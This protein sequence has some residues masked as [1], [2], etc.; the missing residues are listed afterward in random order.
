[1]QGALTGRRE[2]LLQGLDLGRSLGAEIGPLGRPLVTRSDGRVVYIDHADAEHLRR[3]Y[4]DDPH[5]DTDRIEVDAVWGQDTLAQAV[6][7]HAGPVPLDYVVASHVIEH[8]PDLVTWLQEIAECLREHGHLRL[9]IPDRRYTFDILRRDS[10]L[11]AVLAA[12]ASRARVPSTHAVL[13]F[14]LHE[15]PVDTARAW[16]GGLDRAELLR[17]RPHTLAGALAV[18]L[19]VARNGT[20][21]DVHCWA[22]TPRSFAGLMIE[23]A[24]GGLVPF[25]CTRF[26]DTEVNEIEFF[27]ALQVCRDPQQA[28]ASWRTVVEALQRAN[29]ADA[30]ERPQPPQPPSPAALR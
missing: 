4:R 7:R 22:F 5:V 16:A 11:A 26:I 10:D 28:E 29:A 21:H 25:A 12:Y 19:D 23:L 6:R 14:C 20:Y 24:G 1:M 27:A 15:T 2:K 8:V 13:D 9:A 17:N 30:V 3:K 18:A